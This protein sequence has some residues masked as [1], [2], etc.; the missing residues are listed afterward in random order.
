MV[1]IGQR[2]IGSP[3]SCPHCRNNIK[4]L[5][6]VDPNASVKYY[7]NRDNEKYFNTQKN[8]FD[9]DLKQ[10]LEHT[11]MVE[12]VEDHNNINEEANVFAPIKIKDTNAMSGNKSVSFR[13]MLKFEVVESRMIMKDEN[14]PSSLQYA[15]SN[16]IKEHVPIR[17]AWFNRE[18][19]SAI[20]QPRSLIVKSFKD[21]NSLSL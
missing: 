9:E 1:K 16:L 21:S 6:N 13:E 14:V 19:N 5:K 12:T 18:S 15:N 20:N 17:I 2:I 3:L 7:S 4:E 8:I 11:Q 10:A